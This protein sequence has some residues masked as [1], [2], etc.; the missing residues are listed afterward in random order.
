MRGL[1]RPDSEWG[2]FRIV[3]WSYINESADYAEPGFSSENNMGFNGK[4]AASSMPRG[5]LG[6]DYLYV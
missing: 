4:K 5:G 3:I 1:K 2:C 6:G